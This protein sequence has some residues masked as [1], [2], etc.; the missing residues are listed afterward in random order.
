MAFTSHGHHIPGT[1]ATSTIATAPNPSRCGGVAHCP[2]C[3]SEA[4]ELAGL[5]H[6]EFKDY[7]VEA[8]K[9]LSEHNAKRLQAYLVAGSEVPAYDVY[10]VQFSKVLRNWKAQGA[11]TLPDA[12]YY[13]ITHDGEKNETY[14]DTYQ[15]LDNVVIRHGKK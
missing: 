14:I 15:K 2:R 1:I 9:I 8:K 4:E 13:E 6:G 12:L 5:L 7:Q 3:K 10:L 11:S